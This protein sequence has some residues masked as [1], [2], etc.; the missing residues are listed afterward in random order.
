MRPKKNVANL[1]SAQ[2]DKGT[3][4]AGCHITQIERDEKPFLWQLIVFTGSFCN[5]L[6]H[7]SGLS[8]HLSANSRTPQQSE[9]TSSCPLAFWRRYSA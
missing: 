9:S 3:I 5:V 6:F 2:T 8:L 1:I 7:G 4:V